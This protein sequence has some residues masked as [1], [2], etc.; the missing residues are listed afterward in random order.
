MHCTTA[1]SLEMSDEPYFIPIPKNPTKTSIDILFQK[2]KNKGQ[3]VQKVN[4]LR[5]Y[6]KR[7]KQMP[8]AW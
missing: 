3:K 8:V 5:I 6:V 7:S 4:I 2:I 1:A